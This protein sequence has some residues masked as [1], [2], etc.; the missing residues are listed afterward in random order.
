[1]GDIF[2]VLEIFKEGCIVTCER[3]PLVKCTVDS[4]LLVGDAG[5]VVFGVMLSSFKVEDGLNCV[6]CTKVEFIRK[7]VVCITVEVV[8]FKSSV[9]VEGFEKRSE[10]VEFIGATKLGDI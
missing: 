10:I 8:C 5:D 3:K 6:V 9:I 4:N 2:R 1:M 7:F